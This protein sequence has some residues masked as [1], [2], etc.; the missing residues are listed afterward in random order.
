MYGLFY[1]PRILSYLLQWMWFKVW[2]NARHYPVLKIYF[3]ILTHTNNGGL[4]N[5]GCLI[6]LNWSL[7]KLG[8][9]RR[10]K[11]RKKLITFSNFFSLLSSLYF[12]QVPV[13]LIND[14]SHKLLLLASRVN[15]F[16]VEQFNIGSLNE[17]F[18]VRIWV[19]FLSTCSTILEKINVLNAILIMVDFF[20]LQRYFKY[21]F[22]RLQ[23]IPTV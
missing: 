18:W 14:K 19:D 3:Y 23:P 22:A 21:R 11:F 10:Y 12:W 5:L 6:H 9:K 1:R 7:M 2:G 17:I 20:F 13:S 15:N 4:K 16:K 8:T